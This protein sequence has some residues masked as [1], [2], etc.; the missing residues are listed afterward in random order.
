MAVLGSH[1]TGSKVAERLNVWRD[2]QL[3]NESKWR[4]TTA[5]LC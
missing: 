3:E 4:W 5:L 1:R 2:E